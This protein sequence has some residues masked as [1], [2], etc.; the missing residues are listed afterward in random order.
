MALDIVV[1]GATGRMGRAL[2]R[3]IQE[4]P[5]LQA[6]G[7]IA[8]TA[9]TGGGAEGTGYPSIVDVPEAAEMLRRCAVL[10][11]F[12]APGQLGQLLDAHADTLKGR[13][14]VVGTTG[15]EADLEARLDRLSR[16]VAVLSAPNFSV[17][18]NLLLGL[19][20]RA[21]HVLPAGLYDVE[22]VEAHH[23]R[24]ED[25]PSGTAL[26]IGRAVADARGVPLDQ[27]RRD[28]RSGRPGA[29]TAGEI[30]FHALRGGNVVGEHAVHFIGARERL[31]LGHTAQ[32]RDLF[33]EGA[34]VAARWI[35]GREPGR[36]TMAQALGLD[37]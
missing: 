23:A 37:G 15:I 20:D 1:S 12:S 18:V 35:S 25:A 26:A 2:G 22:V 28:G 34:L 33:A 31:V 24:K 9:A 29:R 36:Y 6:I 16:S 7:G 3:L 32:S 17:G 30:G 14:L 5:D 13:A 19:V 11:D 21:A 10:V 27:V 4:A 8:R